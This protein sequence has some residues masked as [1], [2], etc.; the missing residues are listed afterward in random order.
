MLRR[1]ARLLV[2]A[3]LLSSMGAHLA[4]IQTVAWAGMAVNFSRNCS[5]NTSLQQTFD[6][7]HPCPL[8]LKIKKASQTGP[9]LGVSGSD[10][11]SDGVI[12]SAIPRIRRPDG[13]WNLT[14]GFAISSTQ[15]VSPDSPPPEI[16]LS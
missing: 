9:S 6:G 2:L 11:R 3:S 10:T 12:F 15:I 16:I 1:V 14:S 8:C 5:L 7:R 13:G 4:V